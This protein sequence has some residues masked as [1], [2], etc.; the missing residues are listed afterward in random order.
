MAINAFVAAIINALYVWASK[1]NNNAY[2]FILIG[3]NNSQ[4]VA[5]AN[6][7]AVEAN[8]LGIVADCPEAAA[9]FE[10]MKVPFDLYLEDNR[11]DKKFEATFQD[12][13]LKPEGW[14]SEEYD[15]S[16]DQEGGEQ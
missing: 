15:Y 10:C 6:A 16:A 14:H 9:L 13:I 4:D 1:W 5:W 12:P 2:F 8:G 3:D 7:N 11:K